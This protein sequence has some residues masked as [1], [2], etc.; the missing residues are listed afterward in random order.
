MNMIDRVISYLARHRSP[1]VSAVAGDDAHRAFGEEWDYWSTWTGL[2]VLN[3]IDEGGLA[4]LRETLAAIE[5]AEDARYG[6][7]MECAEDARYPE[8]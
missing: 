1:N 3:A 7:A 8:I 2:H 5:S 6:S 4:E